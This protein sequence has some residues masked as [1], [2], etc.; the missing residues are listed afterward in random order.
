MKEKEFNLIVAGYGGQGI[1]TIAE[2]IARAAFKQGYDV[3]Q[4]E[5]HGLAQRGGALDCHVRFG[6]KIYSPIV[7]KSG[8]NLIIALEA[9]EALRACYWANSDTTIILNS[10][11]FRSSLTLTKILR[12]IKKITKKV[13]IVDADNIVKKATGSITGANIFLLG[14]ALKKKVLPLKKEA[15][16]QAIKEK[17]KPQFL[18]ENKKVFEIAIK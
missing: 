9:L 16:W 10:K 18:E 3:K 13:Y 17:I 1:L 11:T 2:I 12:E 6:K 15:V 14:Y 4:S 7:M 5:L 8:A